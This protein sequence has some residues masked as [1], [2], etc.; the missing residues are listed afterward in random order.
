LSLVDPID[1]TG[2][3]EVEKAEKREK[4]NDGKENAEPEGENDRS[5]MA[6]V[7]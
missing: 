2:A 5:I 3:E 6:T 4:D 1:S 7:D